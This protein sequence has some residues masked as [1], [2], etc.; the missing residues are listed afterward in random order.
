[1]DTAKTCLV[2]L[3]LVLVVAI[4][5]WYRNWYYDRLIAGVALGLG[6]I[7]LVSYGCHSSMNRNSAGNLVIT[8][9]WL[10]IL[11]FI[12]SVYFYVGSSLAAALAFLAL[13]IFIYYVV[14]AYCGF[15]KFEAYCPEPSS[16]PEWSSESGNIMGATFYPA[17]AIVV[18]GILL[19][20]NHHN[21]TNVGLYVILAYIIGISLY[22]PYKFSSKNYGSYWFYLL[23]GVVFVA[24][25][26]GF[27]Y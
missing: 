9:I 10:T 4:I 15:Q 25:I 24:A 20:L 19:L 21:W 11:I 13:F 18:V 8:I 12:M 22:I 6:L 1:M 17:L 3:W 26:I 5:L 16:I 2:A 23:C 14:V 7:Q 27:F